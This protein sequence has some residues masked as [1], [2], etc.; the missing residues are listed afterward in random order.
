MEDEDI[1]KL[2]LCEIVSKSI[3][4]G[5]RE[6]QGKMGIVELAN[7]LQR[8]NLPSPCLHSSSKACRS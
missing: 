4:K 5:I 3:G 8:S 2:H 1:D 6:L 7:H